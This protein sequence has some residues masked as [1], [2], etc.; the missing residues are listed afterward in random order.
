MEQFIIK[1]DGRKECSVNVLSNEIQ[2]VFFDKSKGVLRLDTLGQ[3]AEVIDDWRDLGH[4][5]VVH[6]TI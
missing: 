4:S 1:L 6:N 2:I 5:V 3:V